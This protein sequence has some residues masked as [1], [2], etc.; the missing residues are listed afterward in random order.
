MLQTHFE[1]PGNLAD[2]L[3]AA[4]DS[5]ELIQVTANHS[6]DESA[7][8]RPELFAAFMFA[9]S[10]AAQGGDAVGFA[11]SMLANPDQPPGWVDSGGDAGEVADKLARLAAVLASRLQSAAVQAGDPGDRRA[12]GHAARQARHIGDLLGPPR[13]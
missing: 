1:A 12:C 7:D 11:P 4:W 13:R 5:F 2:T 9:A 3:A 8:R 10:A 6:A